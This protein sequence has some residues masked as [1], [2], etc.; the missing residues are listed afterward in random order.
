MSAG[1]SGGASKSVSNLSS[2]NEFFVTQDTDAVGA[3]FEVNLAQRWS[4]YAGGIGQRLSFSGQG[5]TV[6]SESVQNL[7]RDE[8]TVRAGMRYHWTAFFDVAAGVEGTQA[9]FDKPQASQTSDNR[10]TAYLLGLFYNRDRFFLNL[11]GG[12]RTGEPHHGSSYPS[13]SNGTGSYFLSYYLSQPLELQA[14]GHQGTQYSTFEGNPYYLETQNGIGVK[15][16]VSYRVILNGY[17]EYGTN[18]YPVAVPLGTDLV[19]RED[20][21]WTAGGG[22]TFLFFRNAAV[23]ALV[24]E[25]K[26]TSNFPGIDRSIF[27]F[28]TSITF[29]G[30]LTR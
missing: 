21:Y 1:I 16:T 6:S 5:P 11:S 24:S 22:L 4:V 14:Y 20:N 10:T 7:D 23:T 30:A 12:Y 29:Q 27:R 26:I 9:N 18:R 13:F 15:I 28:T 3:N 17:G 2:E 25:R 19:K 8:A